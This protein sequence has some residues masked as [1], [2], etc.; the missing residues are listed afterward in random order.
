MCLK[1]M[2]TARMLAVSKP[3]EAILTCAFDAVIALPMEIHT[4]FCT[5]PT[6][7]PGQ[8]AWNLSDSLRKFAIQKLRKRVSLKA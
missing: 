3:N 8:T 2:S 7:E 5:E 1:R 6:I 4:L